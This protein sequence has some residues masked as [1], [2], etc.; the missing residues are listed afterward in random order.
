MIGTVA[1]SGKETF[2]W[3]SQPA[4][5]N[6]LQRDVVIAGGGLDKQMT[7]IELVSYSQNRSPVCCDLIFFCIAENVSY[8]EPGTICYRC[9][10]GFTCL[11]AFD[12]AGVSVAF[13]R[14]GTQVVFAHRL[15]DR[16]IIAVL[17][18]AFLRVVNYQQ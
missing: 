7:A 13:L 6:Y 4:T 17:L 3:N 12:G 16:H 8:I 2:S 14:R 10:L 15:I 1:F 5:F 11:K 18:I 9:S